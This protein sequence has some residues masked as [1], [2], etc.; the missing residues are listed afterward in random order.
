MKLKLPNGNGYTKVSNIVL[1]L[2]LPKLNPPAQLVFLSIYRQTLGWKKEYNKPERKRIAQITQSILMARTGYTRHETITIAIE[3]LQ[4]A[5]LVIVKG[6]PHR[7]KTYSIN[8]ETMFN[9]TLDG[10]EPNKEEYA[11]WEADILELD[12]K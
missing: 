10:I 3:E 2:I 1:D 5:K 12:T 4:K 6:K 9:Y 8:L 11:E 7:A